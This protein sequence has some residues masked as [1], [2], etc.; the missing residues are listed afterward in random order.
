MKVPFFDYPKLWTSD[1]EKLIEI[2]DQTA[3]SG[4]FI[5]QDAVSEFETKLAEFIGCRHSIGVGNATDGMEIFLT[6]LNLKKGD[7]III[8]SHTMLA[9]ASAVRAAGAVPVPVDI[10]DDGLLAV[11]A[12]ESAVNSNTV[13]IMP[14]QLN[15]RICDMDALVDIALKNRLFVTEDAAQ[16]LGARY[17]GRAVGSFGLAADISFFP[18]KTLGCLGDAGAIVTNHEALFE[19]CFEMHDHGRNQSGE[20][21]SWGRNSRLDNIQA[22]IL[23]YKLTKFESEIDRRREIAARYEAQLSDLEVLRLPEGPNCSADRFDTFQNYEIEARDRDSLREFMSQNGVGS[24]VQW[25]GTAIHQFK[26]LGFNYELP[27][28][29]A[30]F[31]KCVLLPMNQFLSDEQVD[32]VCDTVRRFYRR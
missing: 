7:E 12:V 32:H 18:A 22:A 24:L 2:I 3:S 16:A 15:G 20:V 19:Q 13:G 8:S 6:A 21:R 26:N 31:E 5:M 23:N 11:E 9:T 30:F 14:T 27:R 10:G 1:R 28:T 17:K 25:G 29:N 4:G